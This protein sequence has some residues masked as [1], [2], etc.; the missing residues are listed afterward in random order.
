VESQAGVYTMAPYNTPPHAKDLEHFRSIPWAEEHLS[1]PNTTVLSPGSRS[2][3]PSDTGDSIFAL[4][5]NTPATIAAF[6]VF[7]EDPPAAAAER[8]AELKGLLTLGPGL[9]GWPGVCHGGIVATILDEITGLIIPVNHTRDELAGRPR[10][11]PYQGYMTAYLNTKYL[12]PVP[13]GATVLA[14]ARIVKVDG[15]KLLVEGSIWDADSNL[16]ASAEALFVG[17]KEKL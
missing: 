14:T 10:G 16:L 12:R 4:T 1:A 5:L 7:Y 17:L 9:D 3:R 8:V 15:R 11:L 2:P 13:T 6:L